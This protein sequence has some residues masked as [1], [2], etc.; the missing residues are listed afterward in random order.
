MASTRGYV[1]QRLA[2]LGHYEVNVPPSVEGLDP[3]FLP[4]LLGEVHKQARDG[5]FERR[6]MDPT[7]AWDPYMCISE[8]ESVLLDNDDVH[9]RV[10][11]VALLP[12]DRH[13]IQHACDS[14]VGISHKV[15]QNLMFI[16]ISNFGLFLMFAF[17]P[18]LTYV[19][20]CRWP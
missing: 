1:A 16:S 4:R 18:L 11:E 9:L 20:L 5:F 17:F 12:H 10:L 14:V 6:G 2:H 19:S 8:D 3:P 13:V 15:C 7:K